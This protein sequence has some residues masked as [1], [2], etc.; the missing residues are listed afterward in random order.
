MASPEDKTPPAPD[1]VYIADALKSATQ[2]YANA[3]RGSADHALGLAT[4][5]SIDDF[6]PRLKKI[7]AV[8]AGFALR[9]PD[10]TTYLV[11]IHKMPTK[12][13]LADM[14]KLGSKGKT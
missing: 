2:A 8:Q 6:I 3:N 12:A 10:G 4:V 14:M 1:T 7:P 9:Y 13:E 5:G 11:N